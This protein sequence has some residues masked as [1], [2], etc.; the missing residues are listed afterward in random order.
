ME[1]WS[2]LT[3]CM[4]GFLERVDPESEWILERVNPESGW[5]FGAR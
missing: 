5:I 3:Q 2:E 1:V 4:D